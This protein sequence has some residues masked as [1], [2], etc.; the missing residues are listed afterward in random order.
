MKSSTELPEQMKVLMKRWQ[1]IYS[2]I[3]QKSF[4]LAIA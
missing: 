4:L 2:L 3:S 1:E